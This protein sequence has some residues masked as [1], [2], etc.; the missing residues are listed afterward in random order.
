MWVFGSSL[1][2]FPGV[3]TDVDLLV[4]WDRGIVSAGEAAAIRP[5]LS[6]ILGQRI[7][8]RIDITLLSEEEAA[9]S[10]FAAR[11]GAVCVYSAGDAER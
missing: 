11:E 10:Q 2:K 3:N 4:V 7:D 9:S 5:R 1:S 8:R 6:R